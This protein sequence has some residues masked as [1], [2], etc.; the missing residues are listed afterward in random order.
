MKQQQTAS[1]LIAELA[2]DQDYLAM[3]KARDEEIAKQRAAWAKAEEPLVQA[4]ESAGCPVK[5]VWDLVNTT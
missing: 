5:S 4:L 3:R 2:A 1:E